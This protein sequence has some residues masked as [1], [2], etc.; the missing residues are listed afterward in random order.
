VLVV[1]VLVF[2]PVFVPVVVLAT[3]SMDLSRRGFDDDEDDAD[4]QRENGL[5]REL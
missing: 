4:G 2:V 1:V 5:L 3:E